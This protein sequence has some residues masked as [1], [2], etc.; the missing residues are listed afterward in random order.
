MNVYIL[1]R[2]WES[3][4]SFE[5]LGVFGT[6]EAAQNYLY[7]TVREEFSIE[8]DIPNEKLMD[9]L[10]FGIRYDIEEHVVWSK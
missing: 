9:E 5:N 6:K 2:D 7:Q 1:V 10:P 4:S 3:E 8:D